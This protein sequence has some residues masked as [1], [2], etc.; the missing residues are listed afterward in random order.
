MDYSHQTTQHPVRST[1]S[2][3]WGFSL[4][5]NLSTEVKFIYGK[6][7][8]Q[9]KDR[10]LLNSRKIDVSIFLRMKDWGMIKG[11]PHSPH[12]VVNF[13]SHKLMTT[14]H[15]RKSLS[16]QFFFSIDNVIITI[17][18][19]KQF[20]FVPEDSLELKTW[21]FQG[22]KKEGSDWTPFIKLLLIFTYIT[23]E[24]YLQIVTIYN[25]Q[26]QN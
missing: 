2:T 24:L 17:C 23:G 22:Y 7:F 16:V 14:C 3:F 6:I 8:F 18:L 9:A 10:K 19:F 1:V 4:W 13:S 5:G 25:C 20:R 15:S 12:L 26:F 21:S 11:K